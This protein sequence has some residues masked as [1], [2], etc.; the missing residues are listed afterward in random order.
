MTQKCGGR[1]MTEEQIHIAVMHALQTEEKKEMRRLGRAAED[2]RIEAKTMAPVMDKLEAIVAKNQVSGASSLSAVEWAGMEGAMPMEEKKTHNSLAAWL[3]DRAKKLGLQQQDDKEADDDDDDPELAAL[4]GEAP[5][6]PNDGDKDGTAEAE[7]DDEEEGGEPKKEV[8]EEPEE[9]MGATQKDKNYSAVNL[10]CKDS[11]MGYRGVFSQES[12]TNWMWY[13][14]IRPRLEESK[15]K[16]P[17]LDISNNA[18]GI[19][20]IEEIL[21]E[22]MPAMKVAKEEKDKKDKKDDKKDKKDKK[23]DKKRQEG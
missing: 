3:Q 13:R 18:F 4:L 14:C 11:K 17:E 6:D 19:E 16:L 15:S 22:F 23:D 9:A 2:N 20:D 12:F 21:G 1:P 10:A 7:S 5:L 8:E